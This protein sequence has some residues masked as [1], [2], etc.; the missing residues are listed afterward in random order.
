M[1]GKAGKYSVSI[2]DMQ[3]DED[4]D[5]NMPSTNY[6]VVRISRDIWRRSSFGMIYAG[7]DAAS[8]HWDRT[9]AADFDLAT[10]RFLGNKNFEVSGWWEQN[11]KDDWSNNKHSTQVT[12]S[13]PNDLLNLFFNY[14]EADENYNP[15]VGFYQ[16][17]GTRHYRFRSRY[18][19]RPNIPNLRQLTF[20][21]EIW[22]QYNIKTGKLETEDITFSP[23]GFTTKSEDTFSFTAGYHFDTL[24]LPFNLFKDVRI[25]VGDYDWVDY[26]ATFRTSGTRP[27]SES[28]TLQTG[29][30]YSGTKKTVNSTLTTKFSRFLS[31]ETAAI[32]NRLGF[33]SDSFSTQEYSVRV[34]TNISPSIDC[35]TFLQYNNGDD[36]L[37]LNFRIHYIPQV[38]S[39]LF[40]VFNHIWDKGRDYTTTYDATLAK[41]D[42][43]FEF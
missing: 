4:K 17:V 7:L 35:R 34:N 31:V 39:D 25:P 41:I 10:D 9:F 16:R 38:G 1:T 6:S 29:G 27:V 22:S 13:Y 28:L 8:G 12:V 18:S 32:Y 37:N 14:K 21:Q 20:A 26:N 19:P 5:L 15:E 33:E 3:T 36:L 11:F 30:Y 40:L 23:I 43:R 2:M 42:W 24:D